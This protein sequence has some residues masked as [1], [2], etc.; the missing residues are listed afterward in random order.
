MDLSSAEFVKSLSG[1]HWNLYYQAFITDMLE[2]NN[3]SISHMTSQ[4][5]SVTISV[6]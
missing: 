1:K 4:N 2:F 6:K 3:R 5:W